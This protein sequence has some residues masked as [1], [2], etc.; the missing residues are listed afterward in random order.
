[1]LL[2]INYKRFFHWILD[3]IYKIDYDLDALELHTLK[4]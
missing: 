1:M 3:I 2:L 4:K